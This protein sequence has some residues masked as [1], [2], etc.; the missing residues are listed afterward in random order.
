MISF[1]IPTKNEEKILEISIKNLL[2]YSGDKEIIISDGKSTD[3][4]VAIAKKCDARIVEY[5]SDPLAHRQTIAEGRNDG[6]RI[7]LGDYLLFL[8]ADVSI[9]NPD[10]F[11]KK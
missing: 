7:A 6:A 3:A 10:Q 9:N 5:S 11:F 8:D 2:Q 1:I 4:T